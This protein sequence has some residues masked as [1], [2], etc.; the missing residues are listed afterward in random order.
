LAYQA[1]GDHTQ[2]I[3]DFTT[4]LKLDP[5]DAEV[6]FNRGTSYI[7]LRDT[8]RAFADFTKALEVSPKYANAYWKKAAIYEM[9]GDIIG[10][11]EAYTEFIQY[12]SPEHAPWIDFAKQK[13]RSLKQHEYPKTPSNMNPE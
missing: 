1:K 4:A 12:A 9:R 3:A 10:A 5:K 11:V 8:D 13:I 6:Y 2:A 7:T